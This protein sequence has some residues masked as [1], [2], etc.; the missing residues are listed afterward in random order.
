[1]LEQR[2]SGRFLSAGSSKPDE[3]SYTNRFRYMLRG[4]RGLGKP[5]QGG[6]QP[7]AAAYDEFFLGFGKNVNEN[8]FDQNRLGLLLGYRFG[9]AF[10]AEGGFLSQIVQLSR[11]INGRNVFQYN[12][13][14]ILNTFWSL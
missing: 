5:G 12:S 4:Q 14:I 2:I 11:E 9:P 1:M 13:G 6:R 3:W 10:R 7:Y 8:V